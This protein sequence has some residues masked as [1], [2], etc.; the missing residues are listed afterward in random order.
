MVGSG[1]KGRIQRRDI[2]HYIRGQLAGGRGTAEL[3][4][5]YTGIP[6]MPVV[7]F[8]KFGPIENRPLSRIQRI[9]GPFLQRAWLNIPHVTYQDEAD[10]TE[11]EAFRK[12]SND[13]VPSGAGRLTPLLFLSKP[14]VQL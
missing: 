8:A 1:L 4:K 9:S 5:G 10:I 3:T 11:L 2:E 7:D 12:D 6:T 13:E 14:L